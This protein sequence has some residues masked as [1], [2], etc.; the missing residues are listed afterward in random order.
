MLLFLSWYSSNKSFDLWIGRILFDFRLPEEGSRSARKG[1]IPKWKGYLLI[2]YVLGETWILL[3]I[4]FLPWISLFLYSLPNY[5]LIT[6]LE[7]PVHLPTG[8]TCG[9]RTTLENRT[10]WNCTSIPRPEGTWR[11]SPEIRIKML[12]PSGIGF[13]PVSTTSA[14]K[15]WRKWKSCSGLLV[16]RTSAE[17]LVGA[18]GHGQVHLRSYPTFIKD[19][20]LSGACS[21]YKSAMFTTL[22]FLILLLV[23]LVLSLLFLKRRTKERDQCILWQLKYGTHQPSSDKGPKSWRHNLTTNRLWRTSV[24]QPKKCSC[25]EILE[26][27]FPLCRL[28]TVFSDSILIVLLLLWL[29]SCMNS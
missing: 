17:A 15:E 28:S 12:P 21:S 27:S 19:F 22:A 9:V 5:F 13:C 26:H 2:S 16:R 24:M 6:H 25:N 11:N 4:F 20:F 18:K 3:N 14:L 8:T 1:W 7:M 10:T 23:M 29:K